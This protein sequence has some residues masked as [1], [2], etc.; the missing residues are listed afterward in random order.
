MQGAR[1]LTF[2]SRSGVTN[3]ETEIFLSGLNDLGVTTV[4]RTGDVSVLKDVE[5]VVASSTRPIK[6][7]VQGALVLKVRISGL[8]SYPK[9]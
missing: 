7:V 2:F 1:H 9:N 8:A 6:G 5:A 3:K 4:V